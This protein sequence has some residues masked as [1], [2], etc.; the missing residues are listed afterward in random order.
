MQFDFDGI[1]SFSKTVV[2]ELDF[3][4]DIKLLVYPSNAEKEINIRFTSFETPKSVLKIVNSVG[5][6]MYE[7]IVASSTM[8]E[9][10]KIDLTGYESG[11]YYV[12]LTD[13][14]QFLTTKFV[15]TKLY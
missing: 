8:L 12:S 13:G 10:R 11:L 7:E 6:L 1:H 2:V 9:N 3:T 4:E 5:E 14:A 15:V